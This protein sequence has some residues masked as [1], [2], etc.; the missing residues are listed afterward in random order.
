M[1]EQIVLRPWAKI[2]LYFEILGKRS[3][4]YHEVSTVIHPIS[5]F[6][7]LFISRS[8][9]AVIVNCRLEGLPAGQNIPPQQNNIVTKAV[10]FFFKEIGEIPKVRIDLIKRIPIGGG[11]GGG[12]SDAANTLIGINQLFGYPLNNNIIYKLCLKLGMDVPFFLEP[13]PALCRGRGEIIE[14]RYNNIKFFCVLVNPGKSLITKDVYENLSLTLTG[15][16]TRDNISFFEKIKDVNSIV[17]YIHNDLEDTAIELCPEIGDVIKLLK[18]VGAIKSFVC[19][20]GAT[21]CGLAKSKVEAEEVMAK[22][23]KKGSKNWWSRV[24][25]SY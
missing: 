23:I 17:K 1:N 25:S 9:D 13:K 6:D 15:R 20:S 18:K 24:V 11:L 21:V 4:G 10:Q 8:K 5:L 3:D 12:S 19:G 22:I 14:K 16:K 7:E 2:N